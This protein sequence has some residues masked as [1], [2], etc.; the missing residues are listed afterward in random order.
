M[1]PAGSLATRPRKIGIRMKN[2]SLLMIIPR[3][4][5]T[6][7]ALPRTRTTGTL[8]TANALWRVRTRGTPMRR[9]GSWKFGCSPDLSSRNL[10]FNW[11]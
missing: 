8:T 7:T 11:L 2:W 5:M 1:L 10:G 9:I 3:T 6:A 4:L